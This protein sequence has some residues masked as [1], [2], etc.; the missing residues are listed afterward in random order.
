MMFDGQGRALR[1][2]PW[3]NERG[4]PCWLST[5]DP[6]SRLSRMA[7][8]LET[9]LIASA[10]YVLEQA[11]ELLAQTAVGER[12]LRFAGTRLAESLGDTLRI[13]ESRGRRLA[14]VGNDG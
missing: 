12:E 8:E 13:A 10:A 5:A 14:S 11:R 9:D 6:D 1:L 2:L 4:G 3:T 7:D